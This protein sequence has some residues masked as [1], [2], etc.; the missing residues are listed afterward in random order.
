MVWKTNFQAAVTV[1][2]GEVKLIG[3]WASGRQRGGRCLRPLGVGI[4]GCWVPPGPT[5][6]GSKPLSPRQ[7]EIATQNY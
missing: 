5:I 1:A 2:A 3:G 6:F 4:H 7:L